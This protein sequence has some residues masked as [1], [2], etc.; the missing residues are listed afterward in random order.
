MSWKSEMKKYNLQFFVLLLFVCVFAD[1]LFAAKHAQ[2]Y[3]QFNFGMTMQD[4]ESVARKMFKDCEFKL[5]SKGAEKAIAIY[6]K[7][8]REKHIYLLFTA[9][10]KILHWVMVSFGGLSFDEYNALVLQ[11]NEKYGKPFNVIRIHPDYLDYAWQTNGLKI[12]LGWQ[13][14]EQIRLS[15]KNVK[16]FES[17]L[18]YLHRLKGF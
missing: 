18:L 11:V 1:T 14:G 12:M 3:K 13:Q 6:P 15:I 17:N 7:N 16:L 8:E 2:A 4:A 10:E 5:E 9:K